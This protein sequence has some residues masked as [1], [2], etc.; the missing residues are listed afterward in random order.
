MCS[1]SLKS[2]Y[3][4]YLSKHPLARKF[5]AQLFVAWWVT[6]SSFEAV[7]C[8]SWCL[9]LLILEDRVKN[10]F[11]S[12]SLWRPCFYRHLLFLL[13]AMSFWKESVFAVGRDFLCR[14]F[15][16]FFL[17]LSILSFPSL[18]NLQFYC[19]LFW[20]DAPRRHTAL[21]WTDHGFVQ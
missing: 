5:T 9:L 11:L 18:N 3:N 10:Q 13:S 12:P 2:R 8:F 6:S 21:M 16:F 1:V 20:V 19:I 7:S 17:P 4:L 14:F 15:F